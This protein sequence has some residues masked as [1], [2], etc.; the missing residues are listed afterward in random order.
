MDY[1]PPHHMPDPEKPSDWHMWTHKEDP[2][3]TIRV[4][5]DITRVEINGKL[6]H[7]SRKGVSPLVPVRN[8]PVMIADV[9]FRD[10]PAAEL[11][12][13]YSSPNS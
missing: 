12:R 4:P 11:L 7:L 13:L 6:R 5:R 9:V 8:L 10:H 2:R 3:L 1:D